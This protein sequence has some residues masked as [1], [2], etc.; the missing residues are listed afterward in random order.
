MEKYFELQYCLQIAGMIIFGIGLL[1]WIVMAFYL[2]FKEK[3][4]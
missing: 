4:K 3:R 1:F 2:Y